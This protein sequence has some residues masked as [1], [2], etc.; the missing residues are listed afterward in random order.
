[1]GVCVYVCSSWRGCSGTSLQIVQI[2]VHHVPVV[3]NI[4]T[5]ANGTFAKIISK[6]RAPVMSF[7]VEI[8]THKHVI[9]A[10]GF[11]RDDCAVKCAGW[12]HLRCSHGINDS[13]SRMLVEHIVAFSFISISVLA[14]MCKWSGGQS[15]CGWMKVEE[16][17]SSGLN[18]CSWPDSARAP[19]HKLWMRFK[20]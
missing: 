18:I 4:H 1:M 12:A 6:L 2:C 10:A 13:S 20:C 19:Q 9:W 14:Y 16:A 7:V 11:I 17:R 8:L 3:S 15:L 5:C